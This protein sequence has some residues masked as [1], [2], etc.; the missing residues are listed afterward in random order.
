ME[1]DAAYSTLSGHLISLRQILIRVLLIA[2]TGMIVSFF[3][4]DYL[5]AWIRAPYETL[6][7]SSLE[8]QIV[9]KEI[10]KNSRPDPIYFSPQSNQKII[11]QSQGVVLEENEKYKM[12]PQGILEVES[13]ENPTTLA[14][15]NPMEGVIVTFKICFWTGLV[16]SS[17]FW[18]YCLLQFVAPG[19]YLEERRKIIPFVIF[20]FIALF[21]GAAFAYFVTI[22]VA[23]HYFIS[24]NSTIGI[25]LWS[26]SSYVS[27]SLLLLLAN[28]IGAEIAL[29]L[30][31]LIHLGWVTVNH[32]VRF[33]R[34]AIV[35]AFIIGAILTPPDILTQFLLAIPLLLMYEIAVCYAKSSKTFARNCFRLIG[36]V[37]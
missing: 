34:Y 37:M 3:F 15:L 1:H 31:F 22:P 29:I 33:R 9:R 20:S 16:G 32:L 18:I 24:F 10:F 27:Y 25:N 26:L 21:F 30:F 2:S 14:I 8:R 7:S 19:L 17:P 35:L 28:A 12:P 36:L 11:S 5:I 13:I 23:N 6:Y 4:Y